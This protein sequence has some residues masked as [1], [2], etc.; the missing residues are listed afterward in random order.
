MSILSDIKKRLRITGNSL[1]DVIQANIEAA[2]T[3][4][5]DA[6]IDSM[7]AD[8]KIMKAIEIYCKWQLNF[9]GEADRYEQNYQKLS[10]TME[11]QTAHR[12]ED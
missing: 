9:N 1:D 10:D 7:I 6:G 4:L 11:K 12:L 2:I 8:A 5:E 3:D